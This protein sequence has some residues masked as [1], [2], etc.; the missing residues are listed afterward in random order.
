MSDEIKL[1]KMQ[2]AEDT[3]ILCLTIGRVT[4]TRKVSS[5]DESI[6]T[7][8]DRDML[9][10]SVDLYDSDEL[11]KCNTFLG[12]LKARVREFAMPSF[13]KGGMYMVKHEAIKQVDDIILQAKEE[14]KP[15]VEAFADVAEE[16]EQEAK[17]RLGS[18]YDSSRYPTRSQILQI[19]SISHNW[20]TMG[21]P[22]SLAKIDKGF[23]LR[24][25]EKHAA[26]IEQAG[27]QIT[28]LLAAE[29]KGLAD[30]LIERLTPDV[31]GNQKR[32]KKSTVDKIHEFLQNFNLRNI[33]SSGEL[34][35]HMETM[36]VLLEGV[37]AQSIRLSDT[38]RD[39]VREGFKRLGES[40]DGLMVQ[41]TR[42][43]NLEEDNDV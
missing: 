35:K 26:M 8:I 18:A 32:F 27:D 41:P 6:Q 17:V 31:D 19:F 34:E 12:H 38:L 11:R 43:I 10:V 23:F 9:H 14:F 15:L 7:D 33:G 1:E 36:R 39:D 21:T 37:D 42:Y 25:K 3:V 5:H 28:K 16:K 22:A 4:N 30:H 13:L 24:E 29:A 40:L 2:V 20:F